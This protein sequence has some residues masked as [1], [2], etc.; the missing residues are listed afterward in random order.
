MVLLQRRRRQAGVMI[1]GV[2]R[3]AGVCQLPHLH[4]L[5]YN[6]I[7]QLSFLEAGGRHALLAGGRGVGGVEAGLDES[8]AGLRCDHRLQFASCERV[9]VSCL[10]CD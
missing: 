1:Y 5:I 4:I 7:R 2:L 8:L 6:V 10:R 3:G 9:H